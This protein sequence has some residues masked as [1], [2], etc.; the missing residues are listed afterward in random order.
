LFVAGRSGNVPLAQAST[1]TAQL[2]AGMA[3]A[4]LPPTHRFELGARLDAF[5]SYFDASH[6]SEDD[7]SPDR[8]SR[9]LPGA[10]LLAEGGVRISGGAGLMAA[11]GIEALLGKTEI[12]THGSR[13]AVV[14]PFRAVAELGFRARF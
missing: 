3:V 10:D 1:R 5:A 14:P 13:V 9:W 7:L 12:Y 4:L 8:R 11:V 6:L 2:G